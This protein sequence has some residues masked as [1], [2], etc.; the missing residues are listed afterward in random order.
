M[1]NHV[2]A[3]FTQ[4]GCRPDARQLQQLRRLQRTLG[5]QHFAMC[6]DL[7]RVTVLSITHTGRA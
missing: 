3:M 6:P 4:Q 5:E 2:D 7:M 1:R